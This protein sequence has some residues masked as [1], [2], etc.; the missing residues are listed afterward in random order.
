M[1]AVS[2]AATNLEAGQPVVETHILAR[3]GQTTQSLQLYDG[4]LHT[5]AVTIRPVGGAANGWVPPT[6]MLNVDVV[7]SYPPLAMQIRMIAIV[8]GVLGLGMVV[9]FCVPRLALCTRR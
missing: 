5:I 2:I 3:Q 6:V 9:G 7:A 4:G 1:T 8:L